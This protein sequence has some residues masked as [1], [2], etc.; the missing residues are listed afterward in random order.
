[1]FVDVN[2]SPF[3]FACVCGD[4]RNTSV[5]GFHYALL[6]VRARYYKCFRCWNVVDD[7]LDTAREL[8]ASKIWGKSVQF[9]SMTACMCVVCFVCAVDETWPNTK[10][11]CTVLQCG[12]TTH[13]ITCAI[14]TM[15]SVAKIFFL[16]FCMKQSFIRRKSVI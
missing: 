12:L 3:A 15:Y 14:S 1:M 11:S 7:M 6:I 16:L 10:A 4:L 9:L 13:F 5:M 8:V 2:F